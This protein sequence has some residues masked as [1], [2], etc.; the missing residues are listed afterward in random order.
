MTEENQG[1]VRRVGVLAEIKLG[2]GRVNQYVRYLGSKV[3]WIVQQ[4]C[5]WVA[6]IR[7][8]RDQWWAVGYTAMI[9][10]VPQR[11]G[12]ARV[13]MRLFDSQDTYGCMQSAAPSHNLLTYSMEQSPS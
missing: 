5:V 13:A 1:N 12:K 9:L 3:K 4:S 10:P 2:H 8:E 7:Q 11:A 6:W